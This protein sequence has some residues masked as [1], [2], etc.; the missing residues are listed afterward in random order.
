MSITFDGFVRLKGLDPQTIAVEQKGAL[1][2]E[3]AN[4]I[5]KES[6]ETS[7]K[8]ADLQAAQEQLKAEHQKQIAKILENMAAFAPKAGSNVKELVKKEMQAN[9]SRLKTL[10]ETKA[11]FMEFKATFSRPDVTNNQDATT[12][13]GVSRLGR[14]PLSLTDVLT[15]IEIT[16]N[17]NNGQVKYTDWDPATVSGAATLAEGGTFPASTAK[18]R[19]YFEPLQKIGDIIG[20][21]DESADDLDFLIQEI[22]WFLLNNIDHVTE[23]QVINGNGTA[24]NFKGMVNRVPVWTPVSRGI[25]DPSIYDLLVVLRNIIFANAGSKGAPDFVLMNPADA[26]KMML[27]K[28]QN[29]NYIIPPFKDGE[30]IRNM[31]I[32]ESPYVAANTLFTGI[33]SMARLYSKPGFGLEFGYA[34]GQFEKGEKSM[35]VFRR[36]LFLLREAD[37]S[38]FLRVTNIAAAVAALAPPA[39]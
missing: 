7:Q 8:F 20:Y 4:Q 16:D 28:D 30:R 32:I 2:T 37:K 6:G 33:G 12:I 23:D 22:E 25:V 36:G 13:S 18:F 11:G 35:R 39:P 29:G 24:P 31:A 5:A 17:N 3:F 27:T 15:N 38:S 34:A 26:E 21:T 9:L 1:F 14:R 19:Q 10:L